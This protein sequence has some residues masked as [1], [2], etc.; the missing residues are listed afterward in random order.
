M[1]CDILNSLKQSNF[2]V[3]VMCIV[4]CEHHVAGPWY[5]PELPIC[6]IQLQCTCVSR[7]TCAW[8]CSVAASLVTSKSF[9][10]HRAM[11]L[12][13]TGVSSSSSPKFL[14]CSCSLAISCKFQQY[15]Y[16]LRPFIRF[17]C[18]DIAF[19]FQKWVLYLSVGQDMKRHS[20]LAAIMR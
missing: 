12:D 17:C 8:S 5:I 13:M 1:A 19:K 16:F 18:L 14:D 20:V 4:S 6:D 3:I 10:N 15:N 2:Y 7:Q 9:S 11:E